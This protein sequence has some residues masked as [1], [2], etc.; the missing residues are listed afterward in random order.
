MLRLFG[1]AVVAL[2]SFFLWMSLLSKLF[3]S[4][5]SAAV[6]AVILAFLVVPAAMLRLWPAQL[7]GKDCPEGKGLYPECMYVITIDGDVM[8]VKDPKGELSS[9]SR[10]DV[11]E[12]SIET[13]DSG[14]WGADVWWVLKTA[15]GRVV[16]PQGAT[17]EEK[18]LTWFQSFVGFK[19]SVVIEAMGCTSNERF[20]CWKSSE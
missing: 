19:D 2:A 14:P 5:E 16:F 11:H 13:N 12:I 20:A 7:A 9:I 17:G 18:A 10:E 6:G 4:D 3:G 8:Q 15:A 1:V